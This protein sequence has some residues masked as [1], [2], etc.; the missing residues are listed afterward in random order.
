MSRTFTFVH[1]ADVH[2][3]APFSGVDATDARVRDELISATYKAFDRIAALAIERAVDFVLIAGDA[4]NSP[5]RSIRA[6][7]RFRGVM[8]RLDAAGI[9]VYLVHGNH[10]PASG[11]S[12]GLLMPGNVRYFASNKVE[13]IEVLDAQGQVLCA[14][15]GRSYATAKTTANL[16]AGFSRDDSDETAIGVLHANVGGQ[17]DYEPYAPCTLQDLRAARMDYWALGHIHKPLDLAEVPRI[18]YSG[19]PQ[20]LNPKEDGPHGCWV[21]TM[22]R[23]RVLAEE[24]VE[25]ASV[26]WARAEIDAA[27]L[28]DVDSVR[29]ALRLTC[30]A[31]R[32]AAGGCPVIVRIDLTGRSDAHEDLERAS[33]LV[34]IVEELREEQLGGVPWLWVDRVRNLTRPSF[35]VESLRGADDFT[36]DL[37]RIVDEIL[38]D[39]QRTAALLDEAL[40]D[41]DREFV[42]RERDGVTLIER[43]RDVCLDRLMREESR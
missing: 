38:A 13:R 3:D 6:Q 26:R 7:L 35:D 40:A 24:F 39:P 34:E 16:A 11:F 8:E 18:R 22:D 31:Q 30:E 5:D 4:Y 19:S 37:V 25:T 36:G 9:P 20:G 41:I 12:A 17:P 33:M 23:G 21:V 10:D 1:A 29:A 43:A 32:E 15:Y 14:L 42:V 2:L 27:P 28:A